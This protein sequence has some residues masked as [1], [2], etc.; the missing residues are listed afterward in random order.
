MDLLNKLR[1]RAIFKNTLSK[2][3]VST[4]GCQTLC[5]IYVA[6]YILMGTGKKYDEI[7]QHF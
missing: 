3:K 1:A 4:G 5:N 6:I 7:K 2:N